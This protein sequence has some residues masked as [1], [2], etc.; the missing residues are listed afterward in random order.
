MANDTPP[1][2]RGRRPRNRVL[3]SLTKGAVVTHC[4]LRDF[5][6]YGVEL[7]LFRNGLWYYSHHFDSPEPAGREADAL[8][9]HFERAGWTRSSDD[10]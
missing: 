9:A 7:Q 5:G 8:R 4:E 1:E 10:A 2:E 3:W 6:Q